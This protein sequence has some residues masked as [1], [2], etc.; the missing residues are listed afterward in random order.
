MINNVTITSEKLAISGVSKISAH[1]TL[2]RGLN[3]IGLLPY[4]TSLKFAG[5]GVDGQLLS[6]N[7]PGDGTINGHS[8]GTVAPEGW[9]KLSSQGLLLGNPNPIGI[10]IPDPS[11]SQCDALY[12][13]PESL[14]P[15]YRMFD[16]LK[17]LD[18]QPGMTSLCVQQDTVLTFYEKIESTQIYHHHNWNLRLALPN[19]LR[20]SRANWEVLH[21]H[22]L[23]NQ[24]SGTIMETVPVSAS[25]SCIRLP[26][27]SLKEV[28]DATGLTGEPLLYHDGQLGFSEVSKINDQKAQKYSP[29]CRSATKFIQQSLP[30]QHVW[31][32]TEDYLKN[33]EIVELQPHLYI[34]VDFSRVAFPKNNVDLVSKIK[35]PLFYGENYVLISSKHLAEFF[36]SA[37]SASRSIDLRGIKRYIV[38]TDSVEESQQ[39]YIYKPEVT[40]TETPAQDVTAMAQRLIAE[41]PDTNPASLEHL[42]N[43]YQNEADLRRFLELKKQEKQCKLI[44]LSKTAILPLMGR[45]QFIDWLTEIGQIQTCPISGHKYIPNYQN[46]DELAA[47]PGFLNQLTRNLTDPQFVKMLIMS[48]RVKTLVLTEKI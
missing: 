13:P 26:G 10:I 23:D 4:S 19:T 9:I 5:I 22:L 36:I 33:S 21:R 42:C 38:A 47:L 30:E 17:D 44:K 16:K 15:R 46:M 37:R 20:L 12:L 24:A 31:V 11:Y 32:S 8:I 28:E 7:E 3:P 27:Q 48:D 34:N 14:P 29:L 18:S 45:Q 39:T 41:Y 40:K 2:Q 1:I 35:H 6:Y 43:K 25:S